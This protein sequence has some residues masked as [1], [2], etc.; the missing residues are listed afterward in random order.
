[1][2]ILDEIIDVI[3]L[4][5]LN[6][7]YMSSRDRLVRE[8]VTSS[9]LPAILNN[10]LKQTMKTNNLLVSRYVKPAMFNQKLSI[11][12]NG[13]GEAVPEQMAEGLLF[14]IPDNS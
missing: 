11:K 8:P 12:Y 10:F 2:L 3:F 5:N 4:L 14:P 7:L 9:H 6:D 1:M 13:L